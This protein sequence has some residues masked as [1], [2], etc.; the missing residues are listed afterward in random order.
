MAGEPA[1]FLTRMLCG[2]QFA[3]PLMTILVCHEMGHF[4]QAHRYGVYA[5]L[6]F[7]IPMP[8]S[9]IGTMGAVIA[10]EPRVG[11]RRALFDIGITGPLAG[12]VPTLIFC[13]WG[14]HFSTHQTGTRQWRRESASRC[15]FSSLPG[16]VCA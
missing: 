12:L 15:C 1:S 2:L 10:M 6:P 11:G 4:I 7:F 13:I 8:V 14:L 5:S 3:V 9:P 16:D